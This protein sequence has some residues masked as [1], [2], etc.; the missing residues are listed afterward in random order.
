MNFHRFKE[1]SKKHL[2]EIKTVTILEEQNIDLNKQLKELKLKSTELDNLKQFQLTNFKQIDNN[3]QRNESP[4]VS[5][6]F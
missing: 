4:L 3:L 2:N 5:L 1:E 6:M